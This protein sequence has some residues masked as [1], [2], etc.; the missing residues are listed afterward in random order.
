MKEIKKVLILVLV[1]DGLED[2]LPY[3]KRSLNV[4]LILVLVED[5]LEDLNKTR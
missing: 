4:V 3:A 2:I 5:G 1:E